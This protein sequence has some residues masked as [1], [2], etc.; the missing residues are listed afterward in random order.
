MNALA[1]LNIGDFCPAKVRE[2][3]QHATN[4]WGCVYV[5]ITEPLAPVHHFW[6]K[7]F[8]STSRYVESFDRVLQLDCD[9]LIR[10]DCPSPF[11]LVPPDNIGVVSR[12]Q[13]GAKIGLFEGRKNRWARMMGLL[14][15]GEERLHLNAGLIL[16]SPV[17]HRNTFL[18]LQE[19]GRRVGWSRRCTVPEQFALSCI[20]AH[21][22]V[23]VTWLPSTFNTLRAGHNRMAPPGVMQTYIYHFN[24]PRG[25][26]LPRA[27]EKCEWR[28][29]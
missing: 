6:Q 27:V 4:R 25:R 8:V 14:P 18:M 2:S 10:S 24:G 21:S 11:D 15:Y 22:P 3:F 19:V 9:M 13:R 12:V 29:S 1:V 16:Y 23:P 7:T 5:E 26:N 28:V 20:L 17:R